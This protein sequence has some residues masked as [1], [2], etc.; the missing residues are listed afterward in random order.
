MDLTKLEIWKTEDEIRQAVIECADKLTTR[1][2]DSEERVVF[3]CLI[4]GGVMFYT[5]LCKYCDI[6]LLEMQFLAAKSYGQKMESTGDVAIVGTNELKISGKHVVIVDDIYDTGLTMSAVAHR[7]KSFSPKSVSACTL[8]KK[9]YPKATYFN[10]AKVAE[11]LN[12][13]YG[14][15][16]N[17]N[18]FLIGYGLDYD[19]LYR[20]LHQVYRVDKTQE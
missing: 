19:Q 12:L 8:F 5:D 17:E 15:I 14:I 11:Q 6:E 4:K 16:A 7:L 9:P 13:V 3:L 18:D 2:K 1:F 10:P 20:N